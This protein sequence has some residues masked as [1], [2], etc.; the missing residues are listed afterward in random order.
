[1]HEKM[2]LSP[3]KKIY[4]QE[5]VYHYINALRKKRGYSQEKLA[6]VTGLTINQIKSW[7]THKGIS[8]VVNAYETLYILASIKNMNVPEFSCFLDKEIPARERKLYDWEQTIL[9]RFNQISYH[10]RRD[11]VHA[12]FSRVSDEE[13]ENGVDLLRNYFSLDASDRDLLETIASKLANKKSR[14]RVK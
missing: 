4:L 12:K 1:M 5:R 6:K 2:N 9:S 8:P 3:E 13:F 11:L 14:R 7:E 10:K